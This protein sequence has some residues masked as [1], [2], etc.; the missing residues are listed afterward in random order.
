MEVGEEVRAGAVRAGV[1]PP[2]A[3]LD[4][5]KEW[6]AWGP[7]GPPAQ[8][9][10]SPPRGYH[11]PPL[12]CLLSCPQGSS[13]PHQLPCCRL[14]DVLGSGSLAHRQV[15]QP[16]LEPW[17]QQ[18]PQGGLRAPRGPGW[19]GLW[20][21]VH[22]RREDPSRPVLDP[23][24][25]KLGARPV[26]GYTCHTTETTAALRGSHRPGEEREMRDPPRTSYRDCRDAPRRKESQAGGAE[27]SCPRW[28]TSCTSVFVKM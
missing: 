19:L 8:Q 17:L 9:P 6:W 3:T 24:G 16:Q 1:P 22:I 4:G 15:T 13:P 27:E 14:Q 26:R 23:K 2:P 28:C 11:A 21:H 5:Q 25:R 20:V 12:L 10:P 18:A 7:R